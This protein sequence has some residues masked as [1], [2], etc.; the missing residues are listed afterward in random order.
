MASPRLPQNWATSTGPQ[1]SKGPLAQPANLAF[2]FRFVWPIH[3]DPTRQ[4]LGA[5]RPMSTLGQTRTWQAG[6][7]KSALP[8]ISDV[9]L[10]GN[11]EG[12]VHLDA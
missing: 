5:Y 10:L 6:Q 7:S 9:N 1:P 2:G 8:L 4:A 12:V 3:P 11:G